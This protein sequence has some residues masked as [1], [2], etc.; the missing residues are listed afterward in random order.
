MEYVKIFSGSE[1]IAQAIQTE[2]H[3]LGIGSRLQ[4]HIQ[5]AVLAGFGTADLAVDVL[6][7]KKD[8]IQAKLI[9]SKMVS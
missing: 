7:D 5:S 9:V 3:Q 2:L 4:N 6:V 1:I 8:V